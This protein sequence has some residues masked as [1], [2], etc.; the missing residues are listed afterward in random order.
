VSRLSR[1]GE[2]D[3]E[4]IFQACG[5]SPRGPHPHPVSGKSLYNL[6]GHMPPRRYLLLVCLEAD[7]GMASF[8]ERCGWVSVDD[9]GCVEVVNEL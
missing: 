1:S 7:E 8:G 3:D 9:D 6:R 5:K 4:K 2:G